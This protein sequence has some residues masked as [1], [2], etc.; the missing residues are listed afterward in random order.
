MAKN[1]TI[2]TKNSVADFLAGVAD[3][4]R[5]ADCIR[6]A[7]IMTKETGYEPEMWGTAIV[8]FGSYDYKYESGHEGSAP[9]VAFSPRSNAISLY[10]SI[11]S[12]EREQ[13]REQLGKHKS[14]KGCIYISKLSD[15]NQ[16]VLEKLIKASVKHLRK[17]YPA[18]GK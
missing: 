2:P 18:P 15:V 14:G 5:R 11:E 4:G 8:G 16:P 10:T 12:E 13:L 17:K 1:K 7:E 6:L 9:L 3:P